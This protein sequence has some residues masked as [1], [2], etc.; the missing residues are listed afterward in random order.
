[1]T[2]TEQAVWRALEGVRDPEVLKPITELGMV[3][4]VEVDEAGSARVSISLT[5]AGCP[6]ARR[7]EADVLAAT[8]G[9]SLIH[10]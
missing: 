1:M 4:S 5:I 6:A 3:R 7:I 10:I 2:D 9:L 8:Q